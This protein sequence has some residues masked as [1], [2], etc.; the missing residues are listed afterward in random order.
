MSISSAPEQA[1]DDTLLRWKT[2][3][4]ARRTTEVGDFMLSYLKLIY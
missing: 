3:V 4:D 1:L 2:A